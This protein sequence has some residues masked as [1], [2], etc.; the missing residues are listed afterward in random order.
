MNNLV[1][2]VVFT[3]AANATAGSQSLPI[4]KGMYASL[5]SIV[6]FFVLINDSNKE[7]V[8]V[9]SGSGGSSYDLLNTASPLSY[10]HNSGTI[11]TIVLSGVM[12]NRMRDALLVAQKIRVT[13][14]FSTPESG[15]L[16]YY[17][18]RLYFGVGNQF[19]KWDLRN[20]N[21]LS[22]LTSPSAHNQYYTDP[23]V[24][25][26]AVTGEHVTGG[27]NHDHTLYGVFRIRAGSSR[28][29]Q[30]EGS[31]YV[32]YD[33][34]DGFLYIGN[35]TVWKKIQG[36]PAGII[37]MRTDSC[38]PGWSRVSE[39]DGKL[40][41]GNSSYISSA[42]SS[43]HSHTYSQVVSHSHNVSQMVVASQQGGA[44][45]H[46][47]ASARSQNIYGGVGYGGNIYVNQVELSIPVTSSGGAHSHTVSF[48]SV[49]TSATYLSDGTQ[50]TLT[51]YST[52]SAENYPSSKSIIFCR[53]D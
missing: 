13:T 34:G 11:V 23:N 53:K 32:Y 26:S 43:T 47:S 27:D 48:P 35:G 31:G 42:G 30:A 52:G 6:P 37:V 51:S 25:H 1:D 9:V 17:N 14:D 5:S 46:N 38:P 7:V 15:E 10:N 16:V 44:H 4:P 28:P 12:M 45:T 20:H 41:K 24:P 8:E 39:F 50:Q 33:T 29:A 22:D 21:E 2:Q 19:K 49:N 3:L 40:L 36:A 18:N